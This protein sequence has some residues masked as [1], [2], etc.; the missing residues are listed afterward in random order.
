MW[1]KLRTIA[2]GPDFSGKPGQVLEVPDKAG[3]ELVEGGYAEAASKPVP[4][5]P[6]LSDEEIADL[7]EIKRQLGPKEKA[8]ATSKKE[9]AVARD[10]SEG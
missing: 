5:A 1:V 6:P 3:A 7:R 4:P 8:V 9:K 2:A 10:E